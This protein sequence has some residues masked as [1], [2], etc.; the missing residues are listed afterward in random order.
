MTLDDDTE[1]VHSEAMDGDRVK[2]YVEKPVNGGFHSAFCTLPK[3]EWS[4]IRG[5]SS[6]CIA[7][8]EEVIRSTA[9]LIM[10]FAGNGGFANA[11]IDDSRTSPTSSA[12]STK[13]ISRP[14]T[15]C[16][17]NRFQIIRA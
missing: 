10:R 17:S 1:I 8:Y 4:D 5:F 6:Q 11:F 14:G 13:P 16:C 12:S 2:V 7:R 3:Y 9:Y 15:M